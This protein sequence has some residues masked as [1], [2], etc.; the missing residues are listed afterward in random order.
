MF[1]A[2]VVLLIALI[3]FELSEILAIFMLLMICLQRCFFAYCRIDAAISFEN[4]SGK[5]RW[6]RNTTTLSFSFTNM[7]T[8]K[9]IVRPVIVYESGWR[10]MYLLWPSDE[11]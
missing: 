5:R 10:E 1:L 7:S 11:K 8:C 2:L 3:S 9:N 4:N 6:D